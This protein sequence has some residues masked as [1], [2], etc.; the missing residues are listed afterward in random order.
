MEALLRRSLSSTRSSCPSERSLVNGVALA[1]A[2]ARRP[3]RGAPTLEAGLRP[4]F[5]E[6]RRRAG[7][8]ARARHRLVADA[9]RSPPTRLAT[10]HGFW[11]ETGLRL[12]GGARCDRRAWPSPRLASDVLYESDVDGNQTCVDDGA[13][14]IRDDRPTTTGA[15]SRNA[16]LDLATMATACRGWRSLGLRNPERQVDLAGRGLGRAQALRASVARRHRRSRP[17]R[18]AETP[19]PREIPLDGRLSSACSSRILHLHTFHRLSQAGF[20]QRAGS[21]P[22]LCRQC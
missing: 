16:R 9:V 12:M 21:S 13:T 20:P 8:W 3:L 7:R 18:R 22:S 10:I 4:R 14:S 2:L 15:T 5:A 1:H 11:L 19:S 6:H 17:V